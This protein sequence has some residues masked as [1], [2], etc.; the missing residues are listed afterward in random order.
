MNDSLQTVQTVLTQAGEIKE[1]EFSLLEM[2][3]HG[4]PVGIFVMICLF[5][6]FALSLYI[7]LERFFT[8]KKFSNKNSSLLND[9]K[10]FIHEGKFDVALDL[11]KRTH[12]PEGRILYKGLMRIGKPTRDISDAIENT[13]QLEIFELEKNVGVLGTISGA[14]PML[15]FLGTVIGMIIAFFATSSQDQAS[16]QMLAGG[17]YTAM[18]N[19]A[20]GL[21]VGLLAYLFYNILVIRIDRTVYSLQ[22]TAIDFL[23]ILNK[24]VTQP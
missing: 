13:A 6:L 4:G 22:L 1:K 5:I 11:C 17:I 19:T 16:A 15:G 14:A 8:I 23:D 3:T 10:D 24:P 7:F 12:T 21:I 9:I 18:A 2:L 20:S